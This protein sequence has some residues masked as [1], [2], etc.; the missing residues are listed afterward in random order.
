MESKKNYFRKQFLYFSR[1]MVGIT[2]TA[3]WEA[4]A[5]HHSWQPQLLAPESVWCKGPSEDKTNPFS[6]SLSSHMTSQ[7]ATASISH[8]LTTSLW[9]SQVKRDCSDI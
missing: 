2:S 3:A 7:L 6:Q 1:W 5:D 8:T 9:N 4:H